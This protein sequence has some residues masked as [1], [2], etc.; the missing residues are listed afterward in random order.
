MKGLVFL[1]GLLPTIYASLVHITLLVKMTFIIL[2]L[3]S[4]SAKNGDIL[5][6]RNSNRLASFYFPIDVKNAWQLLVKSEDSFG[7]PN[8]FVTTLIEPY[9]AD[10]SKVVSYQTWEDA[11]NINCSPSYGAQFGSPLSTITTQIDMTLI[12]PPLRSGY[13][14][15]T[16]IMKVQRLHLLWKTI[17]QA[18]LDSVR[19]I[20][21]SGSFWYQ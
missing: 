3:V 16:Q 5:K 10:P 17:R 9:N 4:E 6:L 11:S 1:L 12:V 8:A 15:V 21:K 13:Y 2:L 19:A 7:N 18:T 14:V 20:L